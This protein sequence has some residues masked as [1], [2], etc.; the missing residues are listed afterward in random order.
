MQQDKE[1]SLQGFTFPIAVKNDCYHFQM[2]G[3][4]YVIK[5]VIN[6]KQGCPEFELYQGKPEVR[7]SGL[8]VFDNSRTLSGDILVSKKPKKK[9]NFH[10]HIHISD[11]GL[12]VDASELAGALEYK[13]EYEKTMK[14]APSL[15]D[16]LGGFRGVNKAT[17]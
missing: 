1:K 4:R 5:P 2:E 12:S 16:A 9:R 6:P 3:M 8:F 7:L 14:D 17:D 10:L 13:Q 11:T 15:F